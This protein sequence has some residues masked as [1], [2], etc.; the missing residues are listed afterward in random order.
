MDTASGGLLRQSG[1]VELCHKGVWRWVPR[2]KAWG[3]FTLGIDCASTVH[4]IRIQK[5][6]GNGHIAL[7]KLLKF[8]LKKSYTWRIEEALWQMVTIN[9]G[10]GRSVLLVRQKRTGHDAHNWLLWDLRM[11][12]RYRCIQV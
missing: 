5:T 4:F 8:D 11:L 7:R 12:I 1:E 10:V 2:L 9:T 3:P 6:L